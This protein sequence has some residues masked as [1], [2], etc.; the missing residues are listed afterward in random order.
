MTVIKLGENVGVK[1]VRSFHQSLVKAFR[2]D[3]E[4]IIDFSGTRRLDLSVV[5]VLIAAGREARAAS[6]TFRMR[7]ASET[8][9]QQ[10]AMCGLS[11]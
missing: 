3:S 11:R 4:I 8:V 6:K 5:Q 1:S 7:G 10:L 2:D 9:R